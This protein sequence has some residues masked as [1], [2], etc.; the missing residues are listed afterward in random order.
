MGPYLDLPEQVASWPF[1]VALSVAPGGAAGAHDSVGRLPWLRAACS[2]L[3]SL[4]L[5]Q[6]D[7]YAAADRSWCV[8]L[9]ATD[10]AV[11]V[12]AVDRA[13][14]DAAV[15]ALALLLPNDI[16]LA[17]P[18]RRDFAHTANAPHVVSL[19]AAPPAFP[20]VVGLLQQ[21]WVEVPLA[22]LPPA[23]SAAR[24]SALAQ[25]AEFADHL[26]AAGSLDLR[27]SLALQA[28]LAS[29]VAATE[30]LHFVS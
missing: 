30:T 14:L 28:Q 25:A 13:A 17:D 22:S 18:G 24:A 7:L 3:L 23:A 5:V 19:A 16:L 11:Q 4:D 8:S 29:S 2:A 27:T 26:L 21:R 1:Q 12:H 20:L 15:G 10:T 6:P 9:R